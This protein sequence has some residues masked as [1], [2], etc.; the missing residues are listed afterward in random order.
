MNFRLSVPTSQLQCPWCGEG[1]KWFTG[2][3]RNTVIGLGAITLA[4][5]FSALVGISFG[6]YPAR[7]AAYLDPVEALRSE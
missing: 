3:I 1:P 7:R 2:A 5:V 4:V 6:Y